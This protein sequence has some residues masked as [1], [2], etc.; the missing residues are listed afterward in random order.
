MRNRTTGLFVQVP[1]HLVH[2]VLKDG[3]MGFSLK[4]GCPVGPV[5]AIIQME[6]ATWPLICAIK[7]DMKSLKQW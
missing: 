3:S 4:R 5:F 1:V 7:K 2:A 6:T